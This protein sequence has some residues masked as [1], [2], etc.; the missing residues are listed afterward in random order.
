MI[1]LWTKPPKTNT[2]EWARTISLL[3]ALPM[4]FVLMGIAIHSCGAP[5][6]CP[7][8]VIQQ[9]PANSPH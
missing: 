5:C 4:F 2:H 6:G 8:A 7:V 9:A 3:L 1:A